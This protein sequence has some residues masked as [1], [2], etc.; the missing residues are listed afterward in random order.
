MS[1]L[2]LSTFS[3]FFSKLVVGSMLFAI[4]MFGTAMITGTVTSL[5]ELD[6]SLGLLKKNKAP[7]YD[8]VDKKVMD[9]LLERKPIKVKAVDIGS[10]LGSAATDAVLEEGGNLAV[11]FIESFLP[12]CFSF[13]GF[14][15]CRNATEGGTGK[16]VA[17]ET[18]KNIAPETSKA[19]NNVLSGHFNNIV[20]SITRK[21]TGKLMSAMTKDVMTIL[22]GALSFFDRYTKLL[23]SLAD[24]YSGTRVAIGY[25]I[26]RR[27]EGTNGQGSANFLSS[28]KFVSEQLGGAINNSPF[29]EN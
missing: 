6:A 17:N 27:I 18:K 4:G 29:P 15:S 14:S 12:N 1:K 8:L 28:D 16:A 20:S 9:I 2:I 22:K 10:D 21:V 24:N 13:S 23:E 26:Y 11:S 5:R 3:R 7:G 19:L 25:L